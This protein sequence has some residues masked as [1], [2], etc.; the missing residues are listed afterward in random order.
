MFIFV[1]KIPSDSK[2]DNRQRR[3]SESIGL[4]LKREGI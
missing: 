3:L 1:G 2:E 4:W